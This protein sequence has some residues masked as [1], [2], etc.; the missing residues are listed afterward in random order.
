MLA[1]KT[2]DLPLVDAPSIIIQI[3]IIWKINRK[4]TVVVRASVVEMKE[5]GWVI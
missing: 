2:S 5:A 4:S 1:P 3:G